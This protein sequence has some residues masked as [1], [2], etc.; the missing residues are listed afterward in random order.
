M[1]TVLR[2]YQ[3]LA[4]KLIREH[5]GKGGKGAILKMPTGGGKTACFCDFLI[6][7]YKKGNNAIMAVKGKALIHQTSDRL[8]REGVPHGIY[9]GGNTDN[10]TEKILLCSIDTLYARKIAPKASLIVVDEVHNSHSDS[11]KWFFDQYPATFKIGVSATPNHKRG[12]THIADAMIEPVKFSELQDQGFLVGGKYYVPYI[13]DLRGVGKSGGDFKTGELG[14]ASK[15]DK[16]LT[17]NVAKVWAENLRGK[18]TLV[19]AVN[20]EHAGILA[21]ALSEAGA[22]VALITG[23][24]KDKERKAVIAG[25]EMG[26]IDAVVSVG[27][28][29]TGV[30]IP[31]LKAILCCRPTKSYN[32]HIQIMGRGTRPFPGKEHFLMYDLS[33]NLL[34]HGRIESDRESHL[35]PDEA[36]DKIKPTEKMIVCVKCYA[37]FVFEGQTECVCCGEPLDHL[38]ARTTGKRRFSMGDNSEVVE[39]KPEPWESDLAKLLETARN[40]GY[41]KGYCFHKLKDKYGEEI[42]NAAWPKIRSAKKWDVHERQAIIQA[43]DRSYPSLGDD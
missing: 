24:T 20:I 3:E 7:A 13:P 23:S 42:A 29:T 28:M 16:A 9:Q 40:K 26:A 34:E 2:P 37:T 18:S 33:G 6:G 35:D 31:S 32:L 38:N 5:A 11:Y 10:T 19:Y 12:M 17:M 22:L 41:R 1:K 15:N 4:N 27:T 30:D 14:E 36:S 8:T 43:P 21:D 39:F 25:L